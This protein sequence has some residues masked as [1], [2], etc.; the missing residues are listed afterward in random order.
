MLRLFKNIDLTALL[1][2]FNRLH[3]FF[4]NCLD[5]NLLSSLFV[6]GKLDKA[7]LSLT[8]ILLEIIE[9]KHI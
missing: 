1:I 6:S 5:R 9:I 7:K 8:E 2:N 3:V 4:V